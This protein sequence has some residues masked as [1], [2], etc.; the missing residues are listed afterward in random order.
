MY[1]DY[2]YY[3]EE[4]QGTN[5]QDETSFNNMAR[6]ASSEIKRQTFGKINISDTPEFVKNATCLVADTYYEKELLD[7]KVIITSE[8]LGPH[9]QHYDNNR[10][11]K[12]DEKY[13]QNEVNKIIKAEIG[14]SGLLFRGAYD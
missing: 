10:Q 5:I 8:S 12:K 13:Y 9:S 4:F 14:P 7:N 6:K 3:T 2:N 11:N 1:V